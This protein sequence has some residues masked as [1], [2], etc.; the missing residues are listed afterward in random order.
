MTKPAKMT[1]FAKCSDCF[2]AQ[3]ED[4][5]GDNVLAYNGYVPD[6]F[7]GQHWG[8]YVEFEIDLATGQILN[9]IAPT[10]DDLKAMKGR[11]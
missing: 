4:A 1:M 6:W 7:P 10:D 9:W 3:F 8:D 11:E 2:S 5:N